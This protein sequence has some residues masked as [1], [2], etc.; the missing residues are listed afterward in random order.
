[1]ARIIALSSRNNAN[2]GEGGEGGKGSR[3]RRGGRP[4]NI[5]ADKGT[6][7][8]FLR[9]ATDH[10]LSKHSGYRQPG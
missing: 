7:A 6:E 4:V 9:H 2:N 1:M 10:P 3:G 5:G 8:M